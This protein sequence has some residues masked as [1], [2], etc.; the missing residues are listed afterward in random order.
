MADQLT[1]VNYYLGG[2]P[3]KAGEGAKVLGVVKA[4][5]V[6]LVGFLGYKKSARN[7]DVILVVD[8]KAPN[9]TPIAKKAGIELGKKQRAL[10]ISGEDRPG[11][12][13]EILGKLAAKGINVLSLHGLSAGA[14]RFGALLCLESADFS[15]AKKALGA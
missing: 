4:A 10:L 15:K 9:L 5:G 8:E 12:G 6:N 11:A 3:H 14:G 13:E 7:A 1:V 2:I